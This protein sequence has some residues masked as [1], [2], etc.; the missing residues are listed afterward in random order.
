M[1]L[2]KHFNLSPGTLD[3]RW[4][5]GLHPKS[6][7]MRA[8]ISHVQISGG[9]FVEKVEINEV[10]GDRTTLQFSGFMLGPFELNEIERNHFAQ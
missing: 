4:Q 2:E 6:E 5:L 10:K 1:L 3:G 7:P 8:F 9:Q